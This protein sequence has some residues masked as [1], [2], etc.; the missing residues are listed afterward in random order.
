MRYA[1]SLAGSH[2]I[3]ADFKLG[4]TLV[5]GQPAIWIAAATGT[6][7]T[8][9]AT[10]DLTDAFGVTTEAATYSTT[11]GDTEGV[12]EVVY[13][14][15]AVYKAKV[16]PSAT[17]DTNYAVDDGFL[18]TVDTANTTGLII[19]DG[20]TGGTN[21]FFNDGM[22]FCV[23]G[24]NAGQS[25]VITDHAA[26]TSVTLTVPFLN[27]LAVGDNFVCSPYAPGLASV[28]MTSDFTQLD[29]SL[30]GAADN[31]E[32]SVVNVTCTYDALGYTPTAPL[33][34]ADIVLTSHALGN[35]A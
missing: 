34:E 35:A 29:G 14:P 18:L 28:D 3:K 32:A 8:P 1:Y 9:A 13:E 23:S 11:Q 6:L 12:C 27:D 4:V 16:V 19:T 2:G 15:L 25:R 5:L 30:D 21:D 10:T 31:A 7:S 17:A 24:A 33:L 20:T 26:S 22:A